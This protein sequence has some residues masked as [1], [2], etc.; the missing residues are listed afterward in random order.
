M[1][2]ERH[3]FRKIFF[4]L[5]VA[6]LILP[7]LML[8]DKVWDYMFGGLYYFQ[9]N[10]ISFAEC[11]E[12][13]FQG[14]PF[15]PVAYL[16]GV[17]LPFQLLKDWYYH[18]HKLHLSRYRQCIMLTFIGAIFWVLIFSY[19]TLHWIVRYLTSFIVM[20][21]IIAFFLFYS[22]DKRPERVSNGV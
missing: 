5:I 4:N 8:L 18:K 7:F 12:L 2:R 11:V 21:I 14:Y 16:F 20:N 19:P 22:I 10:R 15:L 3:I 6:F 17:L 9:N 1:K 13:F